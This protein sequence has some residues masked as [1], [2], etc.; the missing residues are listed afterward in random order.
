M[1]IIVTERLE[2]IR[3][4]NM[5]ELDYVFTW[6]LDI[7]WDLK[8]EHSMRSRCVAINEKFLISWNCKRL[9][10]DYC[11]LCNLT[12]RKMKGHFTKNLNVEVFLSTSYICI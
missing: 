1:D 8:L 9:P 6:I 5:I 3:L 10:R 12:Y 2:L 4:P 11:I 7:N